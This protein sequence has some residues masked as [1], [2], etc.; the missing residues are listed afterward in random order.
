MKDWIKPRLRRILAALKVVGLCLLFVLVLVLIGWVVF[1]RRKQ[2]PQSSGT[3]TVSSVAKVAEAIQ[4]AVTDVKVETAVINTKTE[5]E[6]EK[7]EEI[8]KEPDGK[9]RRERLASWL[10]AKL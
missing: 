10:S 6:R 9:K 3:A 8:R 4:G 2:Q 1:F 5:A 7:L